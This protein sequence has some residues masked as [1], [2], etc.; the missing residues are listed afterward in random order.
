MKKS[1]LFTAALMVSTMAQAQYH[2]AKLDIG[3]V[4]IGSFGALYEYGINDD[5]GIN[6]RIAYY[7]TDNDNTYSTLTFTADFRYYF[8]AYE[9]G[10][11]WFGTAYLKYRSL[12]ASEYWPTYDPTNGNLVLEDYTS[13]GI[14]LGVT[15]GRKWILNDHIVLEC[16]AGIGRYL[17]NFGGEVPENFDNSGPL[18]VQ[19]G[20]LDFPTDIRLG[21]IVGY[22]F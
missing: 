13:G 5:M 14:A 15:T 17:V 20:A 4:G 21:F 19:D 18:T 6:T 1:I 9:G 12:L 7:S 22:R 2:E 8:D 10:D 3:G 11:G 16:Y